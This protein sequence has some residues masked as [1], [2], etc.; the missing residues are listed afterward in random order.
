M[1]QGREIGNGWEEEGKRVRR[2]LPGKVTLGKRLENG[3]ISHQGTG[4]KTLQGEKQ[5]A[6][7]GTRGV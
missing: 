1:Q 5:D 2:L 6:E 4:D 3:R 7:A